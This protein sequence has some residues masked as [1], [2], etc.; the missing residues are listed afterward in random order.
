MLCFFFSFHFYEAKHFQSNQWKL[1]L[2]WKKETKKKIRSNYAYMCVHT[3][4]SFF[5]FFCFRVYISFRWL[6]MLLCAEQPRFWLDWNPPCLLQA[7]CFAWSCVRASIA[8]LAGRGGP[9]DSP[10]PQWALGVTARKNSSGKHNRTLLVFVCILLS[11]R[12]SLVLI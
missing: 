12:T 9:F 1:F 11:D 10:G 8:A 5:F 2:K 3:Y 7:A 4:Y 6:V